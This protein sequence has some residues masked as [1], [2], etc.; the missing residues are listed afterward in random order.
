M[1]AQ[2][3]RRHAEFRRE[4]FLK[5]AA[6]RAKLKDVSWLNV[7]GTEMTSADWQDAGLRAMGI[8][9]GKHSGSVQH[10]LLL[11]NAGDAAQTFILPASAD[12]PWICIFDTSLAQL[13]A[14]SLGTR[15]DYSLTAR[16]AALLEC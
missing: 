11:V 10:L 1:L 13:G 14:Q 7:R 8:S 12:G 15:K 9:Y 5:G 16:S 6:S 3:R 2:I 4:T